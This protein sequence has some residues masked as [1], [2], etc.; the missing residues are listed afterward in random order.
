MDF[1]FVF[2]A[3]DSEGK[4]APETTFYQQVQGKDP[5]TTIVPRL[6][7]PS[8]LLPSETQTFNMDLTNLFGFKPGKYT[9]QLSRPQN[10]RPTPMEPTLYGPFVTS[11]TISLTVTP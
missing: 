6:Y 4:K 8:L 11:N 5:H 2:N 1:D 9:I 7:I 10:H 3:Q